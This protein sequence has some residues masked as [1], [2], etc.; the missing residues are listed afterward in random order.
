[1]ILRQ[2]A[3]I[4]YLYGVTEG[5]SKQNIRRANKSKMAESM[6]ANNYIKRCLRNYVCF[7]GMVLPKVTE[8]L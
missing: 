3:R 6:A 7:E 1:M 4:G 2:C 5:G 8:W